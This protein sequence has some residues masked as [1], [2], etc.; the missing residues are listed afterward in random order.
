MHL[1]VNS[2]PHGYK[3]LTYKS[4]GIGRS[5]ILE[6]YLILLVCE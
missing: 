6:H 5:R 2:F 4:A 3:L 1:K